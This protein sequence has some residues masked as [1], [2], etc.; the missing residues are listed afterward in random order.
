MA[1]DTRR[2]VN[3]IQKLRKILKKSSKLRRPKGVHDLRTR[4]RRLEAMFPAIGLDSGRDEREVRRLLKPVRKKAGKVR[5]MDVLTS[6]LLQLN[7]GEDERECEVQ[8]AEHLGAQRYRQGKKL[9]R[10]AK[11]TA[12]D[13]RSR[14]KTV[15]REIA[16]ISDSRADFTKN[17]SPRSNTAASALEL[18]TE[19]A[20]PKVLNRRNLHPYRKKLK[21]LRYVL[22]SAEGGADQEFVDALGECKDSIGEW[23]DWEELVAIA[24][25]LLDHGRKCK[26]V[27]QLKRVASRKFD[28]ALSKT[29]AMRRDFPEKRTRQSS[30]KR[31]FGIS[32]PAILAA[33]AIARPRVAHRS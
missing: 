8:I 16:A 4:T 9:R 6:L 22:K 29:N 18:A 15:A 23:H 2:I 5:D 30:K 25:D 33:G 31:T 26:L 11:R 27:D 13:L 3:N 21:E 24:G 17:G 20:E 12:G 7:V 28:E 10:M 14:L 19:L 32:Q 1:L